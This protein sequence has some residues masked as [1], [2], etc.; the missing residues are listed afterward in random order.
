[1]F[2]L[3][4]LYI[5]RKIIYGCLLFSQVMFTNFIFKNAFCHVLVKIKTYISSLCIPMKCLVYVYVH[6]YIKHKHMVYIHTHIHIN[7]YAL[8]IYPVYF[9]GTFILLVM[10]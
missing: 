4:H 1:M 10:T 8:H 9:P 5:V 6:I 2:L 3:R 7:T